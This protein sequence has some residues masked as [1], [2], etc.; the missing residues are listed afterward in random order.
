MLRE[1]LREKESK[2]ERV[3]GFSRFPRLEHFET[4]G[5]ATMSGGALVKNFGRVRSSVEAGAREV[6]A[7]ALLAHP[8]LASCGAYQVSFDEP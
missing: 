4:G 5:N 1:M 3:Y 6:M 8:N 2:N 7:A